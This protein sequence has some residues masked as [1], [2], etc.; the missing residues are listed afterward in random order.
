MTP[1]SD[2]PLSSRSAAPSECLCSIPELISLTLAHCTPDLPVVSSS[3]VF[4]LPAAATHPL[5]CSHVPTVRCAAPPAASTPSEAARSSTSR[6]IHAAPK[7]DPRRREA[8]D[9]NCKVFKQMRN[10]VLTSPQL[11]SSAGSPSS[12][13]PHQ[14]LRP[15]AR[16]CCR[17]PTEPSRPRRLSFASCLKEPTRAGA[18]LD[19]LANPANELSLKGATALSDTKKSRHNPYAT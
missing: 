15:A 13:G 4:T 7:Q 9:P 19:R 8:I 17:R 3:I 16:G 12:P 6:Q 5:M 11:R 1:L 14:S 18:I 10:S 2:L